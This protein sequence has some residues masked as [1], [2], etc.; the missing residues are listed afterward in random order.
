MKRGKKLLLYQVMIA[1]QSCAQQ[2]SVNEVRQFKELKLY[3]LIYES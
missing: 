1:F 3:F 2:S